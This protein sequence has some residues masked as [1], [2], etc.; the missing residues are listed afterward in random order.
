MGDAYKLRSIRRISEDL[1]MRGSRVV[2][3]TSERMQAHEAVRRKRGKAMKTYMRAEPIIV[4]NFELLI[5][6]TV[7]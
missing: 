5:V 1:K 3:N 2:L 6:S 7:L 4:I